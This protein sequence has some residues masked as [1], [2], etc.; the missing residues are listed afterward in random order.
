MGPS[1]ASH[2][3][4][5]VVDPRAPANSWH[6]DGVISN[7]AASRAGHISRGQGQAEQ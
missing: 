4:T 2:A 7:C 1:A 5:L 3:A 6:C